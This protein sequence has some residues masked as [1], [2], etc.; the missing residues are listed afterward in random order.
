[1]AFE[2]GGKR[3]VWESNNTSVHPIDLGVMREANGRLC[4]AFAFA[5]NCGHPFSMAFVHSSAKATIAKGEAP[6]PLIQTA[7]DAVVASD[8]RTAPGTSPDD[9]L[10][11]EGTGPNT[12]AFLSVVVWKHVNASYAVHFRVVVARTPIE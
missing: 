3:Q 7:D 9:H 2:R 11:E 4:L 8:A 6:W 5:I 12:I 10:G 1:M